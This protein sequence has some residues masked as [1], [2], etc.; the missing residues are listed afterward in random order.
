MR[1]KTFAS[2]L[3]D[4]KSRRESERQDSMLSGDLLSSSDD[5]ETK[6]MLR[7]KPDAVL[8]R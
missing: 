4:G 3:L 1:A 2:V 7:R 8:R 6:R 5:E